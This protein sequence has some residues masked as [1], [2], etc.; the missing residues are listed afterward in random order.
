MTEVKIK[1]AIVVRSNKSV[2]VAKDTDNRPIKAVQVWIQGLGI[3]AL[4]LGCDG[5]KFSKGDC[6]SFNQL[7]QLGTLDDSYLP[8]FE[9]DKAKVVKAGV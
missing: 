1:G 6:L 7:T 3:E 2:K 4:I 8:I 5:L 9:A